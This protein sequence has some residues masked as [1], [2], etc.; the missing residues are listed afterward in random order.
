MDG[1]FRQFYLTITE[2]LYTYIWLLHQF[3]TILF[4]YDISF[5]YFQLAIILTTKTKL[6]FQF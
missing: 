4:G 6:Y 3:Q 1:G 2:L 5:K